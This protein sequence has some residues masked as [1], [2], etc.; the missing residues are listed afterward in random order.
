MD[1]RE[2][3]DAD[4]PASSSE[5]RMLGIYAELA[6]TDS[7]QALGDLMS[8]LDE[9]NIVL[10]LRA[11]LTAHPPCRR[12]ERLWVTP[13][14]TGQRALASKL[15]ARTSA[16]LARSTVRDGRSWHGTEGTEPDACA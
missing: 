12:A 14:P 13:M 11:F 16:T 6:G 8:G 5:N 10:V 3:L 7:G 1:W 4:L 15:G 9:S 2:A